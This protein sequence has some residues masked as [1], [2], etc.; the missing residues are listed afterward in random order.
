MLFK[1][2]HMYVILLKNSPCLGVGGMYLQNTHRVDI[3][4]QH[5]EAERENS[6]SLVACASPREGSFMPARKRVLL[7]IRLGK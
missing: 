1:A 2:N 7:K 4:G 6:A 5:G 3:W